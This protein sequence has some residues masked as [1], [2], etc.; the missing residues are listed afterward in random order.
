M[1][2]KRDVIKFYFRHSIRHPK[3]PIR[4]YNYIF[5]ITFYFA[6]I[7][8]LNFIKFTLYTTYI[9][10][11]NKPKLYTIFLVKFVEFNAYNKISV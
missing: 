7:E 6:V 2:E 10:N 1:K 4:M 3:L 8:V 5:K 11:K 9:K